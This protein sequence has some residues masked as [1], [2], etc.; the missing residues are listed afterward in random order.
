MQSRKA[1]LSGNHVSRRSVASTLGSTMDLVISV[2]SLVV[3]VI[4]AVLTGVYVWLTHKMLRAQADPCVIVSVIH[5]ESRPTVLQL[6]IQNV[7]RSVANDVRFDASQPIPDRA[8]GLE[9]EK[10]P[11]PGK[12][13]SGPLMTGIP[14]L[15]PSETR[16]MIWGQFGGL[17]KALGDGQ[18]RITCRFR[19]GTRD[20]PPT[21]CVLD[22]RSFEGTDAVDPDG[23]RQCAKPLEH[24][25]RDF[26]RTVSGLSPLRVTLVE[27]PQERHRRFI[28]EQK[29][30]KEDT[31]CPT[32]A[33]D[34][35]AGVGDASLVAGSAPACGRQLSGEALGNQTR[36]LR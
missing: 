26:G 31:T 20:C 11:E 21:V 16:K 1:G 2:S 14:A 30:K 3:T 28:E 17:K 25:A 19:A 18:I 6:V 34:L 32:A 8:F 24:I 22:V 10:V 27:D 13:I 35:H 15:G 7:G 29:A 33:V 12:M 23:A 5:D 4:L 9:P 36:P